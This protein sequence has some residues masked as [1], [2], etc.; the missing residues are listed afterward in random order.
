[1]DKLALLATLLAAA[2]ANAEPSQLSQ[3]PRV[4]ELCEID[5]TI[6]S[7]KIGVDNYD[8]IGQVAGWAL[9]NPDG[10]VVLD[11][12]A[13]STGNSAA[14][15]ELSLQRALAVRDQ[16]VALNVEPERIVVA[17]FGDGGA[18]RA[19]IAENRRVTVWGTHEGVG[20]VVARLGQTEAKVIAPGAIV[21]GR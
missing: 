13:D 12:H 14:N 7:A 15:T 5:F 17:A 16:L 2:A 8:K 21:A 9:Q 1:M 18:Q 20:L 19:K 10:L 3:H 4:G 11:G 6:G